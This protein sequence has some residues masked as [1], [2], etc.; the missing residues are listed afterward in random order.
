MSISPQILRI[1]TI[2]FSHIVEYGY[3]CTID[4]LVFYWENI[5]QA[6]PIS[7]S[8]DLDSV[9]WWSQNSRKMALAPLIRRIA[10]DVSYHIV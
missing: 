10:T 3:F 4:P 6:T 8:H 1:T 5:G 2:L 9:S 7:T